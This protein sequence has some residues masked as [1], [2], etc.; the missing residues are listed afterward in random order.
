MRHKNNVAI[1]ANYTC[2][3][4]NRTIVIAEQRKKVLVVLEPEIG[5]FVNDVND[6]NEMKNVNDMNDV[7]DVSD[8]N[9][10]T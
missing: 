8:V 5:A 6:M 10:V 7:N 9:N 1:F 3:N 2:E 4:E